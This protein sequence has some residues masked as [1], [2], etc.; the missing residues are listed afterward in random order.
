MS[1]P[2]LVYGLRR[3]AERLRNESA[4]ECKARMDKAAEDDKRIAELMAAV[5]GDNDAERF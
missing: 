3:Y 2:V 4:E 5:V 1:N